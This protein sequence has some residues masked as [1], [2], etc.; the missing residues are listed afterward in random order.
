M[1]YFNELSM[2]EIPTPRELIPPAI[3]HTGTIA[4]MTVN[5]DADAAEF[6]ALVNEISTSERIPLGAAWHRAMVV[7]PD[8]M[9]DIADD[10]AYAPYD[11]HECWSVPPR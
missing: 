3:A 10:A 1:G 6:V 9:L 4:L 7:W 11:R 2:G 8:L 5:T